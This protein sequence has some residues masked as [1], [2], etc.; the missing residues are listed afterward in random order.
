MQTGPCHV[1]TAL[2][3][4]L[5]LTTSKEG[6]GKAIHPLPPFCGLL[7][8]EILHAVCSDE[9]FFESVCARLF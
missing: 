7:A 4:I 1:D 2:F 6:K 8:E 9:L 5:S 3:I